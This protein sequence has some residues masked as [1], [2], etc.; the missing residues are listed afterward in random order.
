MGIDSCEL[1]EK[2]ISGRRF[3][4][5]IYINKDIKVGEKIT[6][7]NIKIVR[8]SFGLAPKYYFEIIGKTINKNLSHGDRLTLEDVNNNL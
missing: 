2:Q 4:R 6:E 8:P 3:G 5:S 1:T 7:D